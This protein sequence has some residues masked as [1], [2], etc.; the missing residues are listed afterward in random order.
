MVHPSSHKTPNESNGDVCISG[1]IWIF[2]ACLLRPDNWSVALCVESIVLPYGSLDFIQFSIIT[3][4][5]LGVDYFARC[6]FAPASAIDSILVLF[7][8][9]VVSI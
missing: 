1:K 7:G 4:A 5:V 9:G 8:L 3:G 2:L 6:I